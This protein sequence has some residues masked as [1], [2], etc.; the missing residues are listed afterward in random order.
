[1]DIP[2][3]PILFSTNDERQLGVCLQADDPVDDMNARLLQCSRP[4][5]IRG[6]IESRF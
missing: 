2:P 6:L 1:M 4:L 3:Y 5:D